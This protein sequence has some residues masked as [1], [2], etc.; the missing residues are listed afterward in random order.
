MSTGQHFR[1]R[2]RIDRGQRGDGLHMP[3]PGSPPQIYA[4]KRSF[5]RELLDIRR[6]VACCYGLEPR[7]TS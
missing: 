6:C 5:A 4:D 1:G 2:F 3:L 7:L